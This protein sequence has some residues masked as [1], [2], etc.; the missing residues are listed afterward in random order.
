MEPRAPTEIAHAVEILKRGGLVAFPTETVYGLAADARNPDAVRAI[1]TVKGRPADHPLIVHLAAA[2]QLDQVAAVVSSPARR[3]AQRFWPGPLT[4]VVERSA[5][6]PLEVTGGH[7][8]VAVRVPAHPVA[9]A[10]LGAFGGWL[11]APS[12][13]RF[14]CVSPTTAEH[15]R[16][17]L[18]DQIELILDGGPCQVGIESTIVDVSGDSIAILRPGAVTIDAIEEAL[19]R[20]LGRRKAPS[21]VPSPGALPRHYQPRARVEVLDRAA[22]E[23]RAVELEQDGARVGLLVSKQLEAAPAAATWSYSAG[24]GEAL[25][26][27]ALYAALRAADDAGVEVILVER[28][29]ARGIGVA[30]LDRL[31]RAA[32]GKPAAATKKNRHRS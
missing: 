27:R 15:V 31:T 17:D 9:L 8:T 29:R 12:A 10:L 25:L 11:A 19:E 23:A 16:R 13:N 30:V 6:V 21:P 28:P 14:G 4:L 26:A 18:G 24:E 1:F 2:E 5:R 3:L 22:L 20:P 32:Q 7:P